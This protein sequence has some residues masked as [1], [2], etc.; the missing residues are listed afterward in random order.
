MSSSNVIQIPGSSLLPE[1]VSSLIRARIA[2][3]FP[4]FLR[5]DSTGELENLS[6]YRTLAPDI[7]R[8]LDNLYCGSFCRDAAP[9]RRRY[10]FVA[11]N[12][13]RGIEFSGQLEALRKHPYLSAADVY[14]LT[15]TD[16]GMARSANRAV[17]QEI[18][19][20][21]GLH[22]SF[23]P[24]YLNLSKGAGIERK[25]DGE[26]ELGL[27]GN[28]V[29]SRYPIRNVRPIYL[30]NGIDKMRG[31]EKRL[32]RQVTL[33]AEIEFPNYRA[34]A[35]TVHLDANSSQ[36]HRCAQ[37]RRV[38]RNLP[39]D[40]PA[41]L[42]GDW[43]TS[44]YNSSRAVYSILG[45]WLRVFMG[46]ENVISNHYLHPENRFERDLFRLLETQ[47]FEYRRSNLMGEPTIQY[48]VDD[49]K[50]R[51]N[52]G[53]WVPGWCFAFIRWALRQHDG[54]C[55]LKLDWFATR[56]V[57]VDSPVIVADLRSSN[58]RPLSDHAA[59]GVDV[60]VE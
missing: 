40:L 12:L 23:A 29:L 7:H 34:T 44:T 16:I 17:A 49:H 15:E 58:G 28:A 50:T 42:G 14:L 10:R 39:T 37:M 36:P 26:N 56:G 21:L 33:A 46:A 27:H 5:C 47:G 8:V 38:V 30:R 25:A 19:Q 22:Y 57:S 3:H 41:I 54:K 59:I 51:M 11:W 45:F 20:A 55:P 48:D 52:L 31:R 18:A 6:S 60:V 9:T 35:V 4:E 43:N 2:P 24:C 1:E 32:G 53:E 13:E